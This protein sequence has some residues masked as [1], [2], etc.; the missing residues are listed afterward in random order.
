V[1]NHAGK[2]GIDTRNIDVPTIE[3]FLR[4]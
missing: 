4:F 3:K 1:L 2:N